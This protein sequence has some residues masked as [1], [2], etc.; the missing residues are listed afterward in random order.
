MSGANSSFT[1]PRARHLTKALFQTGTENGPGAK[2]SG[3]SLGAA[4]GVHF[5]RDL[6]GGADRSEFVASISATD[7]VEEPEPSAVAEAPVAAP[8]RCVHSVCVL[9]GIEHAIHC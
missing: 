1:T 7:D 9:T 8:T 6:Y 3:V 4:G 2:K 5:D